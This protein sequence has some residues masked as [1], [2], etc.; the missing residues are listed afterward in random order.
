MIQIVPAVLAHTL[1]E[2]E[3][4]LAKFNGVTSDV[5]IDVVDGVFA[6][7]KTWPFAPGGQEELE[8]LLEVAGSAPL[9]KDFDIEVDL[10][11]EDAP[12]EAERWV[13]AGATRLVVHTKSSGV[14]ETLL[15]YQH[16]RGEGS[17]RVLLGIALQNTESPNALWQFDGLYDFVQVM[18]IKKVGYQ[19]QPFEERTLG[20][21]ERLREEFPLLPLAVDGG[22]RM[23][24]ISQLVGAGANR[25]VVGSLILSR[26]DVK[27]ALREILEEAN[28]R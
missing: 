16:S 11:V 2:I 15:S 22:V 18:G 10:M 19:G 17:G 5:Q 1:T 25:L 3:A 28:R 27:Q 6:P 12:R 13:R 26:E 23:E 4:I 9:W 20:L 8:N 7:S 24:N 14:R 21:L